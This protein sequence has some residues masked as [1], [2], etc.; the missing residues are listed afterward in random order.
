MG[1]MNR[2]FASISSFS[3]IDF[4]ISQYMFIVGEPNRRLTS[5]LQIHVCPFCFAAVFLN[6]TGGPLLFVQG[7]VRSLHSASLHSSLYSCSLLLFH[8]AAHPSRSQL[9]TKM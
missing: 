4:L 3:E 7:L 8:Q 9:A 2:V 1:H 6:G 5:V